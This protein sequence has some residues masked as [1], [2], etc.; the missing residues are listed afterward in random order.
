MAYYEET[1]VA[2]TTEDFSTLQS[3]FPPL[4]TWY[5]FEYRSLSEP[6]RGLLDAEIESDSDDVQTLGTPDADRKRN[7]TDT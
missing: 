6:Q 1:A 5:S 7:A 2:K 3:A 4:L